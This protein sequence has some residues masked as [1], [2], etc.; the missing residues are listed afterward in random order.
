[1]MSMYKFERY[2]KN[3]LYINEMRKFDVINL[4]KI[5]NI[6]LIKIYEEI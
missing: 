3:F 1:M 2:L 5:Q 4:T 6:R